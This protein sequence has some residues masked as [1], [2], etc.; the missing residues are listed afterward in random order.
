MLKYKYISIVIFF[1]FFSC[2]LVDKNYNV[3]SI[4]GLKP[5]YGNASDLNKITIEDSTSMVNPGKIVL[6]APYLYVNDIDRGIHII[7]NENPESPEKIAFISIP[8][9]RDM[10]IKGDLIYADNNTDLLVIKY[11]DKDSIQLLNR[12][13]NVFERVPSL[14]ADYFGYFECIDESKG[15]VISWIETELDEPKCH[16]N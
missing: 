11:I 2:N 1:T 12:E 6:K 8:F 15:E 9:S 16:T 3:Q 7:N 4:P 5:I 10:A 14:P 13:E